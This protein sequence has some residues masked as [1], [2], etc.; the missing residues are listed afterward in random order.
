MVKKKEKVKKEEEKEVKG[1]PAQKEVKSYHST[2]S[3]NFTAN[4]QGGQERER[5]E[6]Q[7]P[8]MKKYNEVVRQKNAILARKK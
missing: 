3:I 4:F 1:K 5:E 8:C 7:K 2:P 6:V